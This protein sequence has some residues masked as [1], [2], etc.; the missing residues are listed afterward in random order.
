MKTRNIFDTAI[1]LD[2]LN[3][4]FADVVNSAIDGMSPIPT[5]L[6]E[7]VNTLGE[8]PVCKEKADAI[9]EYIGKIYGDGVECDINT[10]D[11]LPQY[12]IGGFQF[13]SWAMHHPRVVNAGANW[14]PKEI[15]DL[16]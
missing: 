12:Y 15:L 11:D 3:R 13:I 4:L 8:Q 9:R 5:E 16:F 6:E 14:S 10:I 7:F 1:E 2:H